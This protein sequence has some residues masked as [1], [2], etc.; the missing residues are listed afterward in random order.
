MAQLPRLGEWVK[1]RREIAAIYDREFANLGFARPLVAKPDRTHAYHLYVIEIDPEKL[2]YDR[3]E[4]FNRLRA[5]GIG[6]NVHYSPVHLMSFYRERFGFK[7][8]DLP[9]AE[10]AAQRILSLPVFPLMSDADVA[11]VIEKVRGLAR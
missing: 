2:G 11:T 9:V 1:R 7:P 6:A 4:A 3:A 5:A 10:R 8:G